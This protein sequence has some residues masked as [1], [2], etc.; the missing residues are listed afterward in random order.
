MDKE[1]QGMILANIA[2]LIFIVP[3]AFANS[4]ELGLPHF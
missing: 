1:R 3:L 4:I 2:Y